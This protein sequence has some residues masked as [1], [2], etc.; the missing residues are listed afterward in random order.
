MN[1]FIETG[2]TRFQRY[3]ADLEGTASD[4]ESG[5][6]GADVHHFRLLVIALHDTDAYVRY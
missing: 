3:H 1:S 2:S 6:A 4:F 5:S